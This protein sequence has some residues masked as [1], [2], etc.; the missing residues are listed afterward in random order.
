MLLLCLTKAP[1]TKIARRTQ[2]G[3]GDLY[4][5]YTG[6]NLGGRI[7]FGV[8]PEALRRKLLHSAKC[9]KHHGAPDRY[10]LHAEANRERPI[11][12][13]AAPEMIGNTGSLERSHRPQSRTRKALPG[14]RVAC[15]PTCDRS[16]VVVTATAVS[17]LPPG[18]GR[19][20]WW[21]EEPGTRQRA[22]TIFRCRHGH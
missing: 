2:S 20:V 13:D 22:T 6:A 3:A 18:G 16:G 19:K 12:A 10:R 5:N 9:R 17:W 7:V 21:P 1:Q 8:T 15:P 11:T 14:R 4:G